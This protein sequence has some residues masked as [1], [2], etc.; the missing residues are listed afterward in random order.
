MIPKTLQDS[1]LP[2]RAREGNIE[3]VI[4]MSIHDS[5]RPLFDLTDDDDD[6]VGPKMAR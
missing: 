3:D 1:V 6:E 4:A 5:G 2:G